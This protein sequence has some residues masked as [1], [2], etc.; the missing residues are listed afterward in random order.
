LLVG[1]LGEVGVE[2]RK[3]SMDFVFS[4]R[5]LGSHKKVP[6]RRLQGD[7][8]FPLGAFLSSDNERSFRN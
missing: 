4:M 2:G 1:V 5:I 6:I 8:E 7:S 3:D